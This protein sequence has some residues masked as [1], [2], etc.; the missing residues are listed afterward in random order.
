MLL[1]NP[2]FTPVIYNA[3]LKCKTGCRTA[4]LVENSIIYGIY[5]N[6]H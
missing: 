5:I 2:R 3:M 1:D 6:H 4:L